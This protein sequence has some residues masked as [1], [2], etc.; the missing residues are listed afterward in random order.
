VTARVVEHRYYGPD[1]VVRA[2]LAS[3]EVVAVRSPGYAPLPPGSAVD[4]VVNGDVLAYPVAR[5]GGAGGQGG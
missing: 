2:R 3:G 1:T 5:A 4:L